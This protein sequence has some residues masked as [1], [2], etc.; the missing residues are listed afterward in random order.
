MTILAINQK[1][2]ELSL[3]GT[4][5]MLIN[6]LNETNGVPKAQVWNFKIAIIYKILVKSNSNQSE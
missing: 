4:I 3:L 1:S 5:L 2:I 6:T